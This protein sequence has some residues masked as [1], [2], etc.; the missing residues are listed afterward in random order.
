MTASDIE[1]LDPKKYSHYRDGGVVKRKFAEFKSLYGTRLCRF[2][3]S[4]NGDCESF[5]LYSSG[6]SF[7]L[8]AHCLIKR[9]TLLTLLATR[10]M[11]SD[12]QREEGVG[13]VVRPNQE[14]STLPKKQKS[15]RE[16]ISIVGVD[17]LSSALKPLNLETARQTGEAERDKAQFEAAYARVKSLKSLLAAIKQTKDM[18]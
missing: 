9:Y 13:D 17:A 15:V 10:A 14:S 6:K 12:A 8:Y 1:G 4:G 18:L 7:I 16:E 3:R 11:Q 5:V 2:E